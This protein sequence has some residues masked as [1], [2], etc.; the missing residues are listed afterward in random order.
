[1]ILHS[2]VFTQDRPWQWKLSDHKRTPRYTTIVCGTSS[3]KCQKIINFNFKVTFRYN[4]SRKCRDTLEYKK[5]LAALQ[6]VYSHLRV[7]KADVQS[8][9]M[10]ACKANRPELCSWG[11]VISHVADVDQ[12]LSCIHKNVDRERFGNMEKYKDVSESFALTL[13][14]LI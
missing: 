1:M 9:S 8:A 13:M 10:K 14:I 6:S 2:L 11:I 3:E 12:L 4:L 7:K 5:T